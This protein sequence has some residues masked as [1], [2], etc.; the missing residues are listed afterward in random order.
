MWDELIAAEARAPLTDID[1]MIEED[2]VHWAL[3]GHEYG[4]EEEKAN[5]KEEE[6]HRGAGRTQRR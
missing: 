1:I 6:Q 3:Y 4:Q 5:G 2:P